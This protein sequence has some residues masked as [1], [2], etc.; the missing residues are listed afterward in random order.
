M[1]TLSAMYIFNYY[2]ITYKYTAS[3]I[4]PDNT[5]T[6]T[7]FTPTVY[8]QMFTVVLNYIEYIIDR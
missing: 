2:S 6:Y 7:D 3:W 1:R 8:E 5:G 4:S